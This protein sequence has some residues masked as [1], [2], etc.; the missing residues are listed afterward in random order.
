MVV[1]PMLPGSITGL[2]EPVGLWNV[3][4]DCDAPSMEYVSH[5]GWGNQ[6]HSFQNAILLAAV[7]DRVLLVPP[8]LAHKALKFGGCDTKVTSQKKMRKSAQR[9]YSR[10]AAPP[11]SLHLFDPIETGLSK[12][13]KM[14]GW[15]DW[16]RSCHPQRSQYYEVDHHCQ[17]GFRWEV[18]ADTK[19]VGW[20]FGRA[21]SVADEFGEQILHLKEH[22]ALMLSFGSIFGWSMWSE[23]WNSIASDQVS[24]DILY[25]RELWQ[26][27]C[28]AARPIHPFAAI[29]IRAGEKGH[30]G[31]FHT[32]Q[33]MSEQTTYLEGMVSKGLVELGEQ[34][35]SVNGTCEGAEAK[36]RK[37]RLLGIS[38]LDKDHFR[39]KFQTAG[40][41]NDTSH[42]LKAVAAK[43]GW[44]WAI[45]LGNP[46]ALAS[47]MVATKSMPF[48]DN[49]PTGM[50]ELLMDIM[51]ASLAQFGFAGNPS[52]TL[53]IHIHQTRAGIDRHFGGGAELC[54]SVGIPFNL[55]TS[56]AVKESLFDIA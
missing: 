15:A 28:T 54:A 32:S 5:G 50:F 40:P 22:E 20:S 23:L 47:Q 48:M 39:A 49:Q 1:A 44:G 36:L 17:D 26:Q 55:T 4:I 52:S 19:L 45:S 14:V 41:Y 34:V 46:T 25:R 8:A 53:S 42:R 30:E 24:K 21:Q 3:S 16:H 7:L 29:H 35:P 56:C 31:V 27:A 18:P 37:L 10:K 6:V 33:T 9:L 2:T 51:L 38:N 12:S 43:H 11:S 13:V